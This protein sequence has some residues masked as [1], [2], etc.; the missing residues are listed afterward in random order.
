MQI[1]DGQ[2]GE[3]RVEIGEWRMEISGGTVASGEWRMANNSYKLAK[4]NK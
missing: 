1:E 4:M 3:G 2:S